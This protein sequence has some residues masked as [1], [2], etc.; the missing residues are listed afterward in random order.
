MTHPDIS[1]A[2]QILSQFM[3]TPKQSHMDVGL[4]V[5]RYL[6]RCPGL[7]LLLPRKKDLKVTAYC[8]SDWGTCLMTRRS[9]TGFCLKLGDSL[10]SWKTKKQSTVSLSSA[11][12]E[13][14]AIAKTTCKIIWVRGLLKDLR[15]ETTELISCFVIIRQQMISQ[16]IQFSM[17]EPS[18]LKL[19]ATLSETK[20]K[21]ES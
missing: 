20:F 21:R 3:H 6:K 16:Q 18:T 4:R 7:G 19:T 1:Y 17:K 12:A 9:L 15:I 2:V 8:D 13:Y 10:I 14:K 11:E 5:I